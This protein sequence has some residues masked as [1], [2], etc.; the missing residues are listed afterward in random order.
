LPQKSLI[1][2]TLIKRRSLWYGPKLLN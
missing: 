2:T 1:T